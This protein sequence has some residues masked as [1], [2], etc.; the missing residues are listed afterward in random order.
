M[1]LDFRPIKYSHCKCLETRFV[2][3][4][5]EKLCSADSFGQISVST[6]HH[7]HGRAQRAAFFYFQ[8]LTVF[9]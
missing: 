5:E 2:A 6:N 1:L 7:G 9:F 8:M 3:I 4:E